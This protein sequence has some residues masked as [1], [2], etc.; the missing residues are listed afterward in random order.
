MA[1]RLLEVAAKLAWWRRRSEPARPEMGWPEFELLLG[2]GFRLQ[3]YVVTET[4]GGPEGAADLV[5]QKGAERFLVQCRHW[6]ATRVDAGTVRELHAAVAAQGAAGAQVAELHPQVVQR[7]LHVIP[8][9][10]EDAL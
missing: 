6:R 8:R 9:V 1:S 4:G 3:G 5:L 10:V 7:L 2:E